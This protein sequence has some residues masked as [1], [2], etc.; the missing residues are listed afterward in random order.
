MSRGVLSGGVSFWSVCT[1][2][3]ADVSGLV[4]PAVCV[5]MN[6]L[7]RAQNAGE[8]ENKIKEVKADETEE[9][10]EGAITAFVKSKKINRTPIK[11]GSKKAD[12][13]GKRKREDGVTERSEDCTSINSTEQMDYN[14]NDE[15][16]TNNP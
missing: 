11:E 15:N 8:G 13:K 3:G 12:R 10:Q 1:G 9:L 4:S 5:N 7:S 2:G 6:E 14:L 16:T